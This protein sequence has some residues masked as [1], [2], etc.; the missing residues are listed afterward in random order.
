MGNVKLGKNKVDTAKVEIHLDD[1]S[2]LP[3]FAA[4]NAQWIE[5]LHFLEDSDKKMVAHP[6]IYIQNGSHVLSAHLDGK[7]AGAVALKKHGKG[8]YEL[9]KMA[10]DSAFRGHGI[11]QTLM[12]ACEAYAKNTLG[13]SRLWL[14]SNTGNAAAIRLYKRNGWTVNHEGPHPVYARANIGMEKDL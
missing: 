8:D 14:L 12:S 2:A 7:V 4:L 5:E 1:E 9:T 13:L 3:R 10:V 6:E 11:G